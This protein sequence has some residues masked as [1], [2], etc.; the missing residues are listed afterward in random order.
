MEKMTDVKYRIGTT[1]SID[2]KKMNR[3]VLEGIFGRLHTI[4][5]TKELQD[6]GTLSTLAITSIILNYPEEV[7]KQCK[8]MSYVDEIGFII[9]N[10][11]RNKFLCNLALRCTG[12]TLLLFNLVEKHGQVLYDMISEKAKDRKVYFIH[13][14]VD[15]DDRENIRQILSMETDVII[16]A[17]FGTMSTGINIPS[18]ENLIFAAPSKSII[19]VLQSI[20]RG[21]RLNEGKTQCNLFDI[22]DNLQWKT[23]KN[24]T[25]K[26]GAERF[27][28]YMSE[29]FKTKLVEVNL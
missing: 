1:G 19:R 25:L 8:K 9:T 4:A 17:S 14:G 3:L 23:S 7:R 20:G 10:E 21:L 26:H 13:G 2:N 28:L 11:R 5:T 12:N 18:I 29:Q 27:K 24:H 15:V 22:T 6:K 16:V